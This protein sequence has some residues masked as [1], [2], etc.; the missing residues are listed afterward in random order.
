MAILTLNLSNFRN[1][2]TK[3]IT[4]D[5]NLTVITG[6]N[7]SGKSNILEAI[8]LL[9]G[10]RPQRV[11]TDLDLI[12]FA[13][14]E[15]KVEARILANSEKQVLTINFLVIDE[16]F[17]KKA[18]FIDSVKKR[19]IDFIN[20]FSIVIFH[21]QDLDLVTGSPSVRRHHMDLTLSSV[22][23]GYHRATSAYSKI[24]VRRNR[25]LARIAD[26]KSKPGELDFWDERLL[27]HGKYVSQKREEFF[28]YLNFVEKSLPSAVSG[29]LSWQI[30]QST[31]SDEK[32]KRNRERDIAAGVTL[33][34]PHRDD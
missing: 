2:L 16:R 19:L 18:Y 15:A 6:P 8:S 24:V 29:N 26:G 23:T 11:E 25:V 1:F 20:Y 30:K 4:L 3:S 31:L 7:G 14:N 27:E 13:K 34:G 28:Q 17:V 12:K 32:V 10:I 21:P 5:K 22:D 33:S 9:S